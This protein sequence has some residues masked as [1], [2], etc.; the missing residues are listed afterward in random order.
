MAIA[1]RNWIRVVQEAIGQMRQFEAF[2]LD[3]LNECLWRGGEQ[4]AISP[5]PF[6]VL[7]YMVE[8]PGRLIT[9]DEMLDALWPE[10]WVQPQVLRTYVLDLRKILGDDAGQP[11]FIQTHSKRGY[12]FVA[13]V[14][15]WNGAQE[16]G[17]CPAAPESRDLLGREREMGELRRAFES[18]AGGARQVIFVSGEPGIGKTALVD[19]FCRDAAVAQTALIAR[20]QC[21]EGFRG[22]EEYYP[23]VEALA[24]SGASSLGEV[25]RR[26]FGKV[27]PAWLPTAAMEHHPGATAPERSLGDLISALEELSRLHPLVLLFEDLQWADD[28]TLHLV[29]ALA[30]RRASA[31]LLVVA[32]CGLG[33][34]ATGHPLRALR[35]DLLMRRLCTEIVLG[36]LGKSAITELVRRQLGQDDL[37]DGLAAFV[38]HRSEGNPLFATALI[39][40]LI[41]Q[42]LLVK[43]GA[44]GRTRWEQRAPFGEMEAQ[45]PA[46]LAQ[47][48]EIEIERL[49]AAEQRILEAASLMGIAFPAWAVAAAL[50]EDLSATEEACNALARRL[51]FIERGGEDELPDGTRSEF[52]VFVHQVYRDVLYHRQSA[53]CRAA[54]HI[55]VANRLGELFAGREASVAREMAVHYEAAGDWQ[56]ASAALRGAACHA[57]QRQAQAEAADLLHRALR[58]AQNLSGP[59]RDAAE[60]ALHAEIA[61]LSSPASASSTPSKV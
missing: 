47:T 44:D 21:V 35:Q 16:A 48:V 29:S 60:T 11:R 23:V 26:V 39:E 56:L 18:L 6:A 19:A 4:I 12:S 54:R 52:Y 51:S 22:R 57:R 34:K 36:P 59:D 30:R 43:A 53:A 9:H 2:R 5:R 14:T 8:N 25:V 46:G 13:P 61:E 33:D 17:A 15:E 40:H 49:S 31:G 42:Q 37:P 32:T 27:A 50:T 3:T 58:L 7:R 45:V 1:A 41:A 10:T 20:G 55:R 38:H 28:S 24:H